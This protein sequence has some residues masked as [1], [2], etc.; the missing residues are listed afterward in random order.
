MRE[1]TARAEQ[2][3]L[4]RPFRIARGVKTAIE[5]V[6]VEIRD[7][8]LVGRGEGVPY[9][10]Y[11]ESAASALALVAGASA[12][13]AAG[14]GR[15]ELLQ[16]LPAG[17][18]R[19]AVDCALWDLQ[20]RQ[21]RQSIWQALGVARPARL[22]TAVTISLDAPPRMAQAA[23]ALA[24]VPLLKVK[25]DRAEP[26]A[27]LHAVRAGAPHPRLIVDPNE[28]WTM[29]EVAGLQPL[30]RELRVDL[31]EQPLPADADAELRGFC[32]LVPIAA[33]ESVHVAADVA[34]LADRYQVINIKLD[35]A[36]G[37]TA[38]LE[39]AAATRGAGLRLMT[40]CMVSTSLSIAPILPIAAAAEFVDLD[41]PWWLAA[42]RTGGVGV[43]AGLLR[44]PAPGFWAD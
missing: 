44:P 1:I 33:D 16:L 14:A 31:L 10:R 5:V 18:A 38:A 43:A 25:V 36:G 12:A 6:T 4:E 39:L 19:N 34:A 13:L 40:G 41:G 37:L 3:A 30:L 42:D 11:G 26:A 35:K 29:A 24:D 7:G 2:F 28:S 27:Q 32:P 17:A 20:C 15:Q 22:P 8:D 9:P 21:Q 23:A